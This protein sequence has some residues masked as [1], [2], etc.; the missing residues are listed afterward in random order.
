MGT[1]EMLNDMVRFA[2]HLCVGYLLP[3]KTG[4]RKASEIFVV[5][6]N[7]KGKDL[8][9]VVSSRDGKAPADGVDG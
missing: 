9:R 5:V 4:A 6:G 2:L 8:K 7:R 3:A 1:F